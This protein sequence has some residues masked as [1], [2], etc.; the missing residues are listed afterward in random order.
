MTHMKL[1]KVAHMVVDMEDDNVAN[2]V[3]DM[4]VADMVVIS[5]GHTA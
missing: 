2:K 1:D 5:V 3:L 4:G